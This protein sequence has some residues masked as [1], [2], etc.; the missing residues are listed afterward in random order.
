MQVDVAL[1]VLGLSGEPTA[2]EVR[3]AY[4]RQVKAHPPERDPEG[5]RRV[6]EA[7][8][9][10]QAGYQA[11]RVA[12]P[13]AEPAPLLPSMP[14]PAQEQLELLKRALAGADPLAAAE[15]MIWLYARPLLESVPVPAPA[16]ALD[17]MLA[18]MERGRFKRAGE[19]LKALEDYAS[20]N[21]LPGGFGNEVAARWKLVTEL[22]ATSELDSRLARALATGLRSG[23]LF[24]AAG[25]ADAALEE[26]GPELQHHM[27]ERA[28][29]LWAQVAPMLSAPRQASQFVP[30]TRPSAFRLG[31]WPAGVVV[32]IVFNL[33]RVCG[34]SERASRPTV[35]YSVPARRQDAPVLLPDPQLDPP[36]PPRASQFDAPKAL[37]GSVGRELVIWSLLQEALRLG[38]CQTVREQWTNYRA[39]P[40]SANSHEDVNASR[41]RRILEMCPELAELLEEP[42]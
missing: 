34:G 29:T 6:R 25:A 38:D 26:Y 12:E 30:P 14:Q 32:L 17:T 28:P 41:K 5:F 36:V 42:Q 23:Q 11:P 22:L 21:P 3:R 31:S 4:L 18:L 39:L 10:L 19:L 9:R 15:S 13:E 20:L 8:D 27:R 35:D 40:V 24:V 1:D 7:Y 2:A 33:I 16:L 37:S